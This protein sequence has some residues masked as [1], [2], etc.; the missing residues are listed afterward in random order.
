M[1]KRYL[2]LFPLFCLLLGACNNAGGDTPVDPPEP[3]KD[4]PLAKPILS[5][6]SDKDGLVWQEIEGAK[7]Y[8]IKEN[9]FSYYPDG[10]EYEFATD[11]G[12]YSVTVKAIADKEEL[13]SVSDP[14]N[15][16]VRTTSIGQF[17]YSEGSID[18]SQYVGLSLEVKIDDGEYVTFPGVEYIPTKDGT[19]TF[20]V[21]AGYDE[22]DKTYYV[23]GTNIETSVEVTLP[24][25]DVPLEKPVLTVNGNKNGLTWQYVEGATKYQIKENET[26]TDTTTRAYLFS[27]TPGSYS[28]TITAVA[29]KEELNSVS[30]P[31]VY[32]TKATDVSSFVYENEAIDVSGYVG[33]GLE[34]KFNDGN[35]VAVKG[36]S[37]VPSDS[38]SYTFRALSGYDEANNVLYVEGENATKTIDVVLP[39]KDMVIEDGSA[40]TDSDLQDM[41]KAYKYDG[42]WNQTSASLSLDSGMNAGFTEGK[43]VKVNYWKH[44]ANFKF[45][46]QGMKF[47]SYDTVSLH[48]K[49]TTDENEKFKLQFMIYENPKIGEIELHGIY[50]TYSIDNPSQYWTKYTISIDD[51]GWKVTVGSLSGT[52]SEA[53]AYLKTQGVEMESFS[54]ILP[55]FDTFSILAFCMAD[56]NW[57]T[58]SFYFDDLMLTND[59]GETGSEA[60]YTLYNDFVFA[61]D[62]LNGK[63]NNSDDGWK[64]TFTYNDN[65]VTLPVTVTLNK[66]RLNVVSVTEGYDFNAYLITND[67]GDTFALDEVSG[68]AAALLAN[69]K[70]ERY[71]VIDDFDS[72]ENVAALKAN[73]YADYYD[74]GSGSAMGGSGWSMMT[75]EDNLRLVDGH[76]GK[77]ATLKY[78][79]GCDMRYT[80]FG[81]S[82]GTAKGLGKGKYLSFWTKGV[83]DR[84]SVIKVSLYAMTKITPSTQSDNRA[85]KEFTIPA[86]S[87]WVE[88]KIDL[89]QYK[90]SMYYGI[91]FMVLKY[92][93]DATANNKYVPIDDISMYNDLSPWGN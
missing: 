91:S 67:S 32:Q 57:S 19:Y 59:H 16:R 37:Y 14:F 75:S 33:L 50:M 74:G 88:C 60:M 38:G 39:V 36:S 63:L 61:S 21:I 54:E 5:L 22:S 48:L 89:T 6:N 25:P 18:V 84:D 30:D 35:Y 51:P 15:Y 85:V 52:P 43:C 69:L 73:Y 56:A 3:E 68:S 58:S 46:R 34:V 76:E 4:N 77:G 2:M 66:N 82:D 55:Y 23:S 12:E 11:D 10:R 17:E 72:Y 87:D 31:F 27:E 26:V 28:V 49:G 44:S 40:L 71:V 20:R 86:G 70:A 64:L 47:N 42:G 79:S 81:L 83:E 9:D 78:N 62:S 8:Q 80:T 92:H 7:Q 45:E 13:S 53:L 90:Y 29:A 93:G 41:Y 65:L 24:N 1:K